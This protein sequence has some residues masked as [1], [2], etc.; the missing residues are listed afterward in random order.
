MTTRWP[1][2]CGRI[3][4]LSPGATS[5]EPRLVAE[6]VPLPAEAEPESDVLSLHPIATTARAWRSV[7]TTIA[8]AAPTPDAPATGP[9]PATTITSHTTRAASR[10][11]PTAV[12]TRNGSR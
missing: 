5:R 3:T 7:E 9:S 11:V 6:F 8:R 2:P 1:V 4:E 10:H 12:R